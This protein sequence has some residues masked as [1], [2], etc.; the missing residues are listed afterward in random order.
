MNRKKRLIGSIIAI[1]ILSTCAFFLWPRSFANV[2]PEVKSISV[3]LVEESDATTYV[4]NAQ[5]S[6]FSAIMDTLD[7]YSYHMS[8]RTISSYFKNGAS[9]E[10]NKAGYWL[11]IYLY[12]EPNRYGECYGI[13]SGGT[14]EIVVDDAVYRIGYLGNSTAL[15]MM[16][17]VCQIVTP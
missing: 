1:L 13:T 16:D 14:G 3:V 2:S 10:G 11:N 5:D 8:L 7:R 4:Y 9:M 12:T 17:E 6:E 15:K